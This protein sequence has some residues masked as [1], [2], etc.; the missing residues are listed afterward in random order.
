MW[1]RGIDPDQERRRLG[2]GWRGQPGTWV[3]PSEERC[4]VPNYP[5]ITRIEGGGTHYVKLPSMQEEKRFRNWNSALRFFEDNATPSDRVHCARQERALRRG[6]HSQAAPAR[7]FRAKPG[8][9][10]PPPPPPPPPPPEEP[11]A[12]PPPPEEPEAPPPPEDDGV[13]FGSIE[14]LLGEM[15]TGSSSIDTEVPFVPFEI[16]V[17]PIF[18]AKLRKGQQVGPHQFFSRWTKDETERLVEA[19]QANG[20][21]KGSPAT[22]PKGW[23]AVAEYVGTRTARQCYRRWDFANPN[24]SEHQ[25]AL[26]K[27][28]LE[29][30]VVNARERK[31]AREE[32]KLGITDEWLQTTAEHIPD[33]PFEALEDID[34]TMLRADETLDPND[35]FVDARRQRVPPARVFVFTPLN[36]K[37]FYY[38]FGPWL[39]A[40]PPPQPT[41]TNRGL[42]VRATPVEQSAEPPPEPPEP[43][44]P[45][46]SALPGPKITDYLLIRKNR[47]I[48]AALKGASKPNAQRVLEL[49][50]AL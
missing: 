12:P 35:A 36:T 37:P 42:R 23:E 24:M 19:V 7:V 46:L 18:P 34:G 45:P 44:E 29:R 39:P 10:S 15:Q 11:E 16:P 30:D 32:A 26:R 4:P 14:A 17:V 48:E 1:W 3:Q 6:S 20:C 49:A 40:P 47:Q 21:L 31:H 43:P 50:E 38:G 2:N 28:R 33:A 13:D 22:N 25:K 5:A 8:P 41:L 9:R 27:R